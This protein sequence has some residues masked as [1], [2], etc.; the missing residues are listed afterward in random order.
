MKRTGF[1]EERIIAVSKEHEAGAK[2]A[3]LARKPGVSEAAIQNWK[4]KFGG[5][6]VFEPKRLRALEEENAKL[7]NLLAE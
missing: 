5:M 6:D 1:T 3:E 2:T 7:K 4:T